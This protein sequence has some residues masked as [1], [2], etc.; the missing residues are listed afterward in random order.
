M[1]AV[2]QRHTAPEVDLPQAV[3]ARTSG[4]AVQLQA[5][6]RAIGNGLAEVEDS[7]LRRR[8][9]LARPSRRVSSQ[10]A[11]VSIGIRKSRATSLVDR[12]VDAALATADWTI[13]RAWGFE[14]RR[15]RARVRDRILLALRT[16][17]ECNQTNASREGG[18]RKQPY[19]SD[20]RRQPAA[21]TRRTSGVRGHGR[22]ASSHPNRYRRSNEGLSRVNPGPS[23]RKAQRDMRAVTRRS[24]HHSGDGRASG[25]RTRAFCH[26]G[27]PCRS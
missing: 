18:S 21:S 6:R 26:L 22:A 7:R 2:R 27:P 1:A 8:S 25:R 19:M 4:L 9:V 20:G 13:I 24:P 11:P 15:D 23:D 3:Y 5:G 12:R 17:I 10:G 16:K 14:V